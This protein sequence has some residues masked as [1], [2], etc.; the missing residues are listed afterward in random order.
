M[1][2]FIGRRAAIAV[3]T[4]VAISFIIFAILDLAPG[5]PTS[6]LP[7]T[8]PREVRE[9][10][11]ESMGLNDP[12]LVKWPL[13]VKPVMLPEPISLIAQLPHIPTGRGVRP[14]HLPWQAPRPVVDTIP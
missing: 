12:F 5:D 7:L 10:I 4:L 13:W 2:W 14:R 6:H 1:L 8:I 11:R 9:Q 3:P